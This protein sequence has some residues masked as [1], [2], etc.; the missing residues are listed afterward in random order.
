M[1]FSFYTSSKQQR[2]S[3]VL[4]KTSLPFPRYLLLGQQQVLVSI[5][6][7]EASVAV[8]LHQ[9]VDVLLEKGEEEGKKELSAGA[10]G[11]DNPPDLGV[12]CHRNL[13]TFEW[14]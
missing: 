1:I 5:G 2:E 9:L 12:G 6:P 11:R 7:Q 14:S 13:G 10:K 4:R 3:T 8:T